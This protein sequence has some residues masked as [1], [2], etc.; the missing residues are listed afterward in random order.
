MSENPGVSPALVWFR[1]DLRLSDNPALETAVASGRPVAALFV[2]DRGGGDPRAPGEASLWW[3]DRSLRALAADL[4]ARGVG[5][6]LRQGDPAEVV[7][8]VA[9][10][11]DAALVAWN[12]VAGTADAEAAVQVALGGVEAR[13]FNGSL[14]LDPERFTSKSGDG[15]RVFTPFWRAA[16]VALDEREPMPAPA[17]G[18]MAGAPAL[19]SEEIADWRLSPT[20]PDW[21]EGFH[22]WTP[23]EAGAQARLE[24]FLDGGLADYVEGRDRPA[25]AVTSRLSPHLAWGEIS[26]TQVFA[27]ARRLGH[28]GAR[29]KFLS[30]LGWR[31][32]AHHLLHRRPDMAT[33][34]FS[35]GIDGFPWRDDP[36]GLGAWRRGMTGYPI[37]DAGMR[38][39]WATGYMHTRVR[40]IAASFLIKHLMIDWRIGERWFWDTLVDADPASNPM[41]WQWVAGC[42]PDASPFFRI[43][44]PTL[45]G[46]RFD[47]KGAYV[48]LW[49]PELAALPDALAHRPWEAPLAA[50]AYPAPIVEH[51]A[52]RT[53]ALDAYKALR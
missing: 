14:L 40:M 21:S 11:I 50:P 51:T 47:P 38:E 42:G 44:N 23:G 45:Q 37:V 7:P 22:D 17:P 9:R 3:L 25:E 32:F 41:N 24:A 52:A 27:A 1:R 18:R 30:E 48:R 53:R 8:E 29:A 33:R 46:E 13:S 6:V 12:R 28:T 43:F 4:K 19:P 31:E 16:L 26:P 39:L 15:Y 36:K 2:L 34:N 5:L 20:A 49:V 35:D 10:E